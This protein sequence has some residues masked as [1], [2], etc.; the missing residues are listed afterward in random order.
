MLKATHKN[1]AD[2]IFLR[3]L[4]HLFKRHFATF[5][6][7]GNVPD[8]PKEYPLIILP[9]HNTW[10]DG[11]FIYDLNKRF[12][13]RHL[14]MMMLEDQLRKY[15]FFRYLGAYGIIPDNPDDVRKSIAYT[16]KLIESHSSADVMVCIFPQGELV[17]WYQKPLHYQRGVELI[18]QRLKIPVIMLPLMIRVEHIKEQYPHVFFKIGKP[19]LVEKDQKINIQEITQASEKLKDELKR[20]LVNHH[21]GKVLFTGRRSEHSDYEQAGTGLGQL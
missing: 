12:F 19:Q 21:Y 9:N 14:Y 20:E 2:Y 15:P 18:V 6:L 11:F 16:V 10:W 8:I 17:S 5:N 4:K 1:W 7:I 13:Q 3:Y